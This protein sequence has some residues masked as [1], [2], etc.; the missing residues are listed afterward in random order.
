MFVEY[1]WNDWIKMDEVNTNLVQYD[2]PNFRY[3]PIDFAFSPSLILFHFN[4]NTVE[5]SLWLMSP[6]T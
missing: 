1:F 5:V 4:S 2:S 3:T 6:K